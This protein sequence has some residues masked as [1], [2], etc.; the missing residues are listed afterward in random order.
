MD[1]DVA[2]LTNDDAAADEV[3]EDEW[4]G[5]PITRVP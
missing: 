5:G 1:E 4:L 3:I 2:G